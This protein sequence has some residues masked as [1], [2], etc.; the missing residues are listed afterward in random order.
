MIERRD[1]E[2]KRSYTSDR[3]S[4]VFRRWRRFAIARASPPTPRFHDAVPRTTL[5]RSGVDSP[6]QKGSVA[7]VPDARGIGARVTG[8]S[9][10][11]E[12]GMPR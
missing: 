11:E 1:G 7:A 2:R 3:Q 5:P 12:A 9:S 6:T 8:F 10:G 4:G